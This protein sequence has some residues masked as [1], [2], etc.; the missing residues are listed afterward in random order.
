MLRPFLVSLGLMQSF[1][2]ATIHSSLV[3]AM[4]KRCSGAGPTLTVLPVRASRTSQFDGS[5]FLPKSIRRYLTPC[6]PTRTGTPK[7]QNP[8][9]IDAAFCEYAPQACLL[10]TSDAADEEDRVD[11]GGR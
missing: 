6:G 9:P 8:A 7:R 3:S 10:Y 4:L 5:S 1:A 2:I 11:L